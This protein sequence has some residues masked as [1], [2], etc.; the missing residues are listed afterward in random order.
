M[1]LFADLAPSE[2]SLAFAVAFGT[3]MLVWVVVPLIFGR[4]PLRPEYFALLPLPPGR[5]AVGL[6]AATF[7]GILAAVTIVALAGLVA[8]GVRL[9]AGPG[10][11]GVVAAALLLLFLALLS[12]VVVGVL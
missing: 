8:Y 6:L 9:G 7:V 12:K 2:A 11:V 3:W 1:G 4:D 5:L 10:L